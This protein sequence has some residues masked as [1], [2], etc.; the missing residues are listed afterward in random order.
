MPRLLWTYFS[1]HAAIFTALL[2][3]KKLRKKTCYILQINK[4]YLHVR[5]P[6]AE[7]PAIERI[8]ANLTVYNTQIH[9][10]KRKIFH[11]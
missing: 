10:I 1:L 8:T 2:Y 6:E 7:V 3:N 9:Y 4:I 11:K 5:L